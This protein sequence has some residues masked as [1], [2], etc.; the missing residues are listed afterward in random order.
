M[1]GFQAVQTRSLI[2]NR[3]FGLVSL[4]LI[5]AISACSTIHQTPV[6][7]STPTS[8]IGRAFTATLTN[9]YTPTGTSTATAMP[10]ETA[11]PAATSTRTRMP[12][13]TRRPTLTPFP[14]HTPR[15]TTKTPTSTPTPDPTLVAAE[16][17]CRWPVYKAL[18]HIY[19]EWPVSAEDGTW[20]LNAL[21]ILF[22]EDIGAFLNNCLDPQ[23]PL[24]SQTGRLLDGLTGT[25][26][27]RGGHSEDLDHFVAVQ[28]DD[29]DD[30]GTDELV[31]HTTIYWGRPFGLSAIFYWDADTNSWN[32]KEIWPCC[33]ESFPIVSKLPIRDTGGCPLTLV[34]GRFYHAD[35]T[36]DV[37]LIWRWK[38]NRPELVQEIWLSGWCARPE[39]EIT[40]EG[41][42][43]VHASEATF[44]C[45]AQP[46]KL[47]ILRSNQYV[48]EE[49]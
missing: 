43:F 42:I 1:N 5:T 25:F 35:S 20:N 48:L 19:E 3:A 14:T 41:H 12:T 9:T 40:K 4:V 30:N 39:W 44:R 22:V 46:A 2:A 36:S 16:E 11:T 15:P 27:L 6:Q 33:G 38:G 7:V 47:Y 45:E 8:T 32:G 24:S 29:W 26:S 31:I 37:L 23:L 28:I 13:P 34:T 49:P 10:T 17:M 21:G 18:N